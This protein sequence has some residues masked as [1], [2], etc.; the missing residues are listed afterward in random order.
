MRYTILSILFV[1]AALA[2][3]PAKGADSAGPDLWPTLIVLGASFVLGVISFLSVDRLLARE[4]PAH[5]P[6][7]DAYIDQM[8]AANGV[9]LH[10]DR[11]NTGCCD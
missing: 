4:E 5:K 2:G 9:H 7:E 1:S 3:T 8:L 6:G 10:L 11:E